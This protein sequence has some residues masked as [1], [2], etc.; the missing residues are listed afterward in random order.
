VQKA[1]EIL[2]VVVSLVHCCSTCHLLFIVV[3][4]GTVAS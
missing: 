2:R 4:T 3:E 1:E